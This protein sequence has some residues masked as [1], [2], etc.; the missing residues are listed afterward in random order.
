MGLTDR[1]QEIVDWIAGFWREHGYGPSMQ[2]IADGVV[3]S[4]AGAYQHVCQ[5]AEKGVLRYDRGVRRSVRTINGGSQ[6]T[7][8]EKTPQKTRQRG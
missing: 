2:D 3:I 7:T 4:R 8:G 6:H 1:Q 5:L